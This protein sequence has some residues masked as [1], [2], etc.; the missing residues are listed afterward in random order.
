MLTVVGSA[1][2]G[3]YQYRRQRRLKELEIKA[4]G[5]PGIGG[6]FSLVTHD[7]TAAVA[8]VMRLPQHVPPGPPRDGR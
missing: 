2:V 1:L 7:V 8:V 5:R 3:F 6:P 4:V